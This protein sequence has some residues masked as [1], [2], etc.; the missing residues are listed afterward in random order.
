MSR[1]FSWFVALRY[2]RS[3]H[4]EKFISI[5]TILSIIGVALSVTSLDITMSILSGFENELRTRLVDATAHLVF[6]VPSG[7]VA[8]F[9]RVAEVIES[10]PEVR[11]VT[12]FVSGQALI[13]AGGGIRGMLVKGIPPAG[14]ARTKLEESASRP[15]DVARL[16]DPPEEGS[17]LLPIV[18]SDAISR[19]FAAERNSVVTMFTAPAGDNVVPKPRRFLVVGS[20][21]QGSDSI[22]AY[23]SLAAAQRVFNTGGG[24]SG[25]EVNIGDADRSLAVAERLLPRLKELSPALTVTDWSETNRPLWESIRLI[26]RVYFLVLMLLVLIASLCI[27]NTLV[28]VVIEKQRDIAIMKSLGATSHD[29]RMVFLYGG[30][31]V[32]LAGSVL[33]TVLAVAGCLFLEKFGFAVDARVF[34]FEQVPV[35]MDPL[36]FALVLLA[37]LSVATFAGWYPAQR[38]ARLRP[39]D[40][41]RYG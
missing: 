24:V 40:A 27:V 11:T 8:D 7:T 26:Q 10:D 31:L 34:T 1:R 35:R 23:T 22:L 19:R 2:L 16:F 4:K 3:R 30:A 36:T 13:R 33:G 9:E 21:G 20:Y 37:A 6:Q 25:I 17:A 39:A 41:L 32:G 5:N 15:E 28:M 12:P 29:V 38:A 14:A 18:L